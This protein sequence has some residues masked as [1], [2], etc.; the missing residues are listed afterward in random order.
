MKEYFSKCLTLYKHISLLGRRHWGMQVLKNLKKRHDFVC[1]KSISKIGP[2]TSKSEGQSYTDTQLFSFL[3]FV[4]LDKLS[5]AELFIHTRHLEALE[6][7]D[8][9]YKDP[10]TGNVVFTR[11][12]HLR[13][14]QCCG[15]ACRHCPYGHKGVLPDRPKKTYN[16]AFYV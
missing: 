10:A 9:T 4:K 13:R 7:G 14:G 11:L 6:R 15:S 5:A 2:S 16:S 1:S 8:D 3:Q 12:A